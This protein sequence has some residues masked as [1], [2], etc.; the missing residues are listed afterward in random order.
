[1]TEIELNRAIALLI[2]RVVAGILFFFQAYDKIFK[3]GIKNVIYTFRQSLSETFLK[4]GLL[5]SVVYISSYLEMI[6]G[7]ML[8]TGFCRDQVLYI[9]GADLLAVAFIFSMIKPMWDMQF[10]FPRLVLIIALLLCPP[11]WDSF[12]I[13]RFF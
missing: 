4:G 3:L 11:E 9:L 5:S 6:G 1:M 8:I 12:T 2:I 13:M 7:A 10:Y